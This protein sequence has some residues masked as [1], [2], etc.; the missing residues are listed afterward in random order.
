MEGVKHL[1]LTADGVTA[2]EH[3]LNILAWNGEKDVAC[4]LPPRAQIR[5]RTAPKNDSE[6]DEKRV[7]NNHAF[8][9]TFPGLQNGHFSSGTARFSRV[10]TP[11]I[12]R[13]PRFQSFPGS[14]SCR[15]VPCFFQAVRELRWKGG[16]A[17]RNFQF[18]EESGWTHRVCEFFQSR[19]TETQEGKKKR[20]K[21]DVSARPRLATLHFLPDLSNA[22][23]TIG[24][25]WIWFG[26]QTEKLQADTPL[27][28]PKWITICT[29]Q[30][31]TQPGALAFMR[32]QAQV[33]AEHVPDP[34]HRR[35]NDCWGALNE[36]KLFS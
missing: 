22:M 18:D 4:I 19:E 24:V 5:F 8:P 15:L 12:S 31:A 29:D 10:G 16:G 26:K 33:W 9:G 3:F 23:R 2:G 14:F 34:Q 35:S 7:Q 28:L 36:A 11:V 1:S 21:F 17:T 20:L 30:E 25:S 13:M 27:E 32:F 6:G